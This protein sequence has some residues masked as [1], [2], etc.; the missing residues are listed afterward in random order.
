MNVIRKIFLL[1]SKVVPPSFSHYIS[2]IDIEDVIN[3]KEEKTEL[4]CFESTET[5]EME[6][7]CSEK[8]KCN[9]IEEIIEIMKLE[10]NSMKDFIGSIKDES[11]KQCI[12]EITIHLLENAI[13]ELKNDQTIV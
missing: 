10:L 6:T 13:D 12:R 1:K 11:E 9:S 8:S 4:N 5:E 7:D 3:S 2:D